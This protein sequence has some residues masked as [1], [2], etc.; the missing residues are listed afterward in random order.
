MENFGNN[1]VIHNVPLIARKL[2]LQ[3]Q[4]LLPNSCSQTA[5]IKKFPWQLESIILVPNLLCSD[6]PPKPL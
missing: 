6:S 3:M 4:K 2:E 5:C 1:L